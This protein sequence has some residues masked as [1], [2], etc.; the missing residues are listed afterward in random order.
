MDFR[1][2]KRFLRKT[3][4]KNDFLQLFSASFVRNPE[5]ASEVFFEESCS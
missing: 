5:A 4:P 1:K 2:V 3:L